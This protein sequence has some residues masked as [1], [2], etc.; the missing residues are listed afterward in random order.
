MFQII[1]FFLD[2][3]TTAM[4]KYIDKHLGKDFIWSSSSA[5]ALPILL[6]KKLRGGLQFCIDY[7]ALN[8]VTIKNRHPIPLIFETMQTLAKA[9]KYIKLNIIH[10]FN[11]I[12]IKESHKWL[13]A[14]NSWYGQFKYF[15]I[16]FGLCNAPNTFQDYINESLREYLDV[17]CCQGSSLTIEGWGSVTSLELMN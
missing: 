6:I 10:A 5:A 3:K 15:V 14:F 16:L 11:Q 1:S 4:K 2:E 12:Q 8:V 7:R 9:V 13:I 17:F